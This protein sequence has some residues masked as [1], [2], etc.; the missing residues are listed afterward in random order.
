MTSVYS[1]GRTECS[2]FRSLMD[3]SLCLE[4]VT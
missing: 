4:N 2:I 1:D 3:L